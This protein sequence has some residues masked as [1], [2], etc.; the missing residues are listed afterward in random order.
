VIVNI[1]LET[2]S[3]DG[4]RVASQELINV[5]DCE[6]GTARLSLPQDLQ[7]KE[8]I[9]TSVP[10]IEVIDGQHRLA[11]FGEANDIGSFELPV[12]AFVGLDLSWQAYLFYTV[13]IKPKRINARARLLIGCWWEFL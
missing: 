4:R 9:P 6:D 2:D 12:V 5:E 13:N 1:L 11:A 7:N 8:W 10:P 3:R